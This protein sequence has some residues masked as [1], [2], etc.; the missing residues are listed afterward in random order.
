VSDTLPV[1]VVIA[2]YEQPV[3]LARA[4]RSVHAQRPRR[5]AEVIVVDDGS[6]DSTAQVAAAHGATVIRH[7]RNRGST[8]ARNTGIAAAAQPWM[9]LLDQDDQWL[10]HHLAHLWALRAGHVL[11]A[12]SALRRREDGGRALLHGPL[13][14]EPL[15]LRSPRRLVYPGNCI[16]LSATLLRT[17]A[18]REVGAFVPEHGV[19]DLDLW[20]RLLERGTAAVSP[21]VTVLYSVHA[22]QVSQDHRMMQ[23]AHI[24]VSESYAGRPW[25]SADLVE[26]WRATVAWNSVR[27]ALR[28]RRV[29]EAAG[30]AATLLE[31]PQRVR[32]VVEM[33]IDRARLRR[34]SARFVRDAGAELIGGPR[35]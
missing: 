5:P 18:V 16:P 24:A 2:G 31:H 27:G 25:W 23:A 8:A 20:I 21:E 14:S 10:P 29:G 32:G 13:T 33:W 1:S 17:D 7:A 12:A 30:H 28:R 15:V 3:M 35:W 6:R 11:V 34:R 19:A 22:E 9:A 26:R 4:L